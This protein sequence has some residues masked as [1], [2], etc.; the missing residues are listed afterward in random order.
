MNGTKDRLKKVGNAIAM[1]HKLGA[2][3][4]IRL[5]RY[6]NALQKLETWEH[7]L[8][9]AESRVLL[10][11]SKKKYYELW[12]MPEDGITMPKTQHRSRG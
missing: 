7:R 4:H 2:K 1:T 3:P 5:I 12:I 11:R 6:R 10:Y 8:R 9:I